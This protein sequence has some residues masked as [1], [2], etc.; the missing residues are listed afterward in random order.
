MRDLMLRDLCG[1]SE[2]GNIGASLL[3]YYGWNISR[4]RLYIDV[5]E[6]T[7]IK[8]LMDNHIRE[9]KLHSHSQSTVLHSRYPPLHTKFSSLL[10]LHKN[11]SKQNDFH[12]TGLDSP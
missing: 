2:R 7:L 1:G 9:Y 12:S 4:T 5:P 11:F 6:I 3:H 8:P 10:L